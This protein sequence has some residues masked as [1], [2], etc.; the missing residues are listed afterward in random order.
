MADD[1]A[2]ALNTN[3]NRRTTTTE[4]EAAANSVNEVDVN[5]K[6]VTLPTARQRLSRLW[7]LLLQHRRSSCP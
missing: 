6:R 1:E 7:I 4:E 5:L 3:T 2:V